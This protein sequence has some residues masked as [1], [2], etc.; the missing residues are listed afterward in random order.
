MKTELL[1]YL[2]DIN[3][4]QCHCHCPQ[5]YPWFQDYPWLSISTVFLVVVGWSW[6]R[7]GGGWSNGWWVGRFP[8]TPTKQ[9]VLLCSQPFIFIKADSA[10]I[11]VDWDLGSWHNSFFC[12]AS[13]GLILHNQIFLWKKDDNELS[14]NSIHIVH[15]APNM[16]SRL[17]I[18]NMDFPRQYI[19]YFDL[20]CNQFLSI[21]FHQHF[22]LFD[23][24]FSFC[25]Q[26]LCFYKI[27]GS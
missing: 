14:Y 23:Y 18:S 21:I 5:N 20:Q 27:L 15:S 3:P 24:L 6:R 12:I 7:W 17:Y 22:I 10:W 25:F 1:I 13:L 9:V 4:Y 8:Y 2:Q 11:L 19:W 26:L 16:Y